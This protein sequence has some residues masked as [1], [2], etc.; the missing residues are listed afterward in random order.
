M[1]IPYWHPVVVH[2]PIVLLLVG[3]VAGAVWAATAGTFARHLALLF[4]SLGA[5]SALVATRTG[6]AIEDAVDGEPNAERYLHDHEETGEWTLYASAAAA[7]A[8]G[9]GAWLERRRAAPRA[10]LAVRIVAG[11]LA[12]AAAGLVARTGHLGGLMTWGVP[13]DTPAAAPPP[14]DD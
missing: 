2:F 8:V 12:L 5:V 13:A 6:E 1:E 14:L 11:L 4:L 7:L 10:R 9:A 3:G